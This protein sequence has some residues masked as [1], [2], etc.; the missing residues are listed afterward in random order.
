LEGEVYKGKRY[1][2]KL[3]L[4]SH[5]LNPP[6]LFFFRSLC[7]VSIFVSAWLFLLAP[8]KP[9]AYLMVVTV[10][11]ICWHFGFRNGFPLYSKGK[12]VSLVIT[13]KLVAIETNGRF[14]VTP[15]NQM[16]LSRGMARTFILSKRGRGDLFYAR[17]GDYF[18]V[19]E[20]A[21]SFEQLESDLHWVDC[22]AKSSIGVAP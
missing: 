17:P 11:T 13:D 10:G 1:Q 12:L 8:D 2:Y 6:G 21:V 4:L 5:L 22:K 3:S 16:T 19:D 18:L 9:V 15:K 14:F 20:D 7:A